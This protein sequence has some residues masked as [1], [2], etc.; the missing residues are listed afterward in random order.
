MRPPSKK[1]REA[2][3]DHVP[4]M[5][6]PETGDEAL[7]LALALTTGRF[8]SNDSNRSLNLSDEEFALRAA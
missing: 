5:P 4:A 1:H 8:P 7:L 6:M 3:P 2:L